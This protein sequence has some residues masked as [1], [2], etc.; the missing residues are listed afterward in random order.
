MNSVELLWGTFPINEAQSR[1]LLP[2]LTRS[3]Q[4]R[5]DSLG[6]VRAQRYLAGRYLA[7]KAAGRLLEQD[8]SSV[9]P[10]AQCAECGMDHGPISISGTDINISLSSSGSVVVAAAARGSHIGVD[11]EKGNLLD[12]RE[13]AGSY[14][15]HTVTLAQWCEYEAS[16]KVMGV[17]TV[18]GIDELDMKSISQGYEVR[19]A[20][21]VG[22]Y[23]LALA[24]SC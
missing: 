8:W 17:G 13:V 19:S 21:Q 3:E 18:L 20:S 5:F 12:L 4:E 14:S 6:E 23:V 1:E 15:N 2:L 11:I 7:R 24:L 16:V 22:E 10:S 9:I